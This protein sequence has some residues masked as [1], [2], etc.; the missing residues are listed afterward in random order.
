MSVS[1]SMLV[2][3]ERSERHKFRPRATYIIHEAEIFL[4]RTTKQIV[5]I[6]HRLDG[7]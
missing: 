2:L 1:S 3:Y 5:T 7:S 4:E 6:S